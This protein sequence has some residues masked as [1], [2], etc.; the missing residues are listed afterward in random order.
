MLI[1]ESIKEG[2][3]IR[4]THMRGEPQYDGREGTVTSV[5]DR[6]QIRG[7]WGGC[8]IIPETDEWEIIEE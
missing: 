6:G 3:R 8:A 2:T 5:D 4:I 7:T 1:R